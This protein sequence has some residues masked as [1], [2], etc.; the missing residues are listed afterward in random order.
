MVPLLL[1][2]GEADNNGDNRGS[3]NN[4]QGETNAA[5]M[6]NF[7]ADYGDHEDKPIPFESFEN[8]NGLFTKLKQ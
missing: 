2:C 8:K 3:T 5:G 1:T 7:T 4:H 6:I